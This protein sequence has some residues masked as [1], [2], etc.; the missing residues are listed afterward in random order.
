MSRSTVRPK[1]TELKPVIYGNFLCDNNGQHLS[2]NQF[3][4]V[5]D[6]LESYIEGLDGDDRPPVRQD[7]PRDIAKWAREIDERVRTGTPKGYEFHDTEKGQ[8]RYVRTPAHRDQLKEWI[9][10]KRAHLAK[11]LAEN[12]AE[13]GSLPDCKY[14]LPVHIA[15]LGLGS[16][17]RLKPCD[18]S[19]MSCRDTRRHGRFVMLTLNR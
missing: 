15:C 11:W 5:L 9:T 12:T 19:Y 13:D 10:T 2:Y 18:A 7:Q 8:R 17:A 14:G 4:T 16:H 1:D 3:S 6:R